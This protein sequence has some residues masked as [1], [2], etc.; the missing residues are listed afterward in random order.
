[1]MVRT[2]GCVEHAHP[3]FTFVLNEEPPAESLVGWLVDHFESA[4]SSGLRFAPGDSTRL[5]MHTLR[6]IDRADGTLGLTERVDGDTWAEHIDQ[7]IR[8]LWYQ[9]GA[10]AK[11]DLPEDLSSIGDD[12]YA[13][14][15]PC[16][17]DAVSLVLTRPDES[18][19]YV[20]AVGCGDDH[21]HSDWVYT[22]LFRVWEAF[23]YTAQFLALPPGTGVLIHRDRVSATG[24]VVADVA[25][26]DKLRTPEG[27]TYFGPDPEPA[28]EPAV[29]SARFA[30]VKLDDGRYST[31][32]GD[33]HGHRDI[34][35]RFSE[36]PLP[37][38]QDDLAQWLVGYLQDAIVGGTRFEPGE[39]IQV[40][41]RLL[42]VA[43]RGDGT[44]GLH[45]QIADGQWADHVEQA[46]RELWLQKEVVASVGLTDLL[47]FPVEGQTAL[48]ASCA[49][50]PDIALVLSRSDPDDQSTSGWRLRC[51]RDHEHPDWAAGPLVELVSARP[52]AVQFL[53]L[54]VRSSVTVEPP[55]HTATGR[56]GVEI[57]LTGR[58]LIPEAGSYVAALA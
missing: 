25:Y 1:M 5:G 33:R 19:G 4:V 20:W 48:V 15:Q 32:L 11:L 36:A 39:T 22:D 47:S 57:R 51:A 42:R 40:G 29:A 23:P 58:Q 46:L 35:I 24:G 2:E 27:G 3:E 8:D 18:L 7:S 38:L 17:R 56:I 53:A 13:A 43:D 50:E 10:A 55:Q 26:Q 14:V 21:E 12:D 41:W 49:D 37:G 54:P 52:F 16:G 34:V 31:G 28:S 45:E 9:A 6:I 44:L 30:T